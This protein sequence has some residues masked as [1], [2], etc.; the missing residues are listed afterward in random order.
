MSS[1]AGMVTDTRLGA[2]EMSGPRSARIIELSAAERARLT[3]VTHRPT[4]GAG[5]VRRVRIVLLAAGQMPLDQ[6]ARTSAS[7]GRRCAP[8]STAIAPMASPGCTIGR[9]LDGRG[10]SPP[11]VTLHLVRLACDLPAQAG[12]ALS[13]WDCAELARQLVHDGV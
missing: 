4:A 10:P 6:I 12:R 9:G 8:G 11:E 7:T 1:A 2:R 13:H 5:L 3:A